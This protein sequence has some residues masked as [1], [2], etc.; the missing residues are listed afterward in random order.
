MDMSISIKG[1]I[2]QFEPFEESFFL[3]VW[4]PKLTLLIMFFPTTNKKTTIITK[5]HNVKHHI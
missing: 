5:L 1:P 3:V 2:N 4:V